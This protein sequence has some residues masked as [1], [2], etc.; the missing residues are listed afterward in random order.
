MKLPVY[1]SAVLAFLLG[2]GQGFS[3][4][5]QAI[6][7]PP[8]PGPLGQVSVYTTAQNTDLR[9]SLAQQQPFVKAVQPLETEVAIFVHPDKTCQTMVG[10][11]GALTDASAE[12]YATLDEATQQEFM[13][14]YFHPEEGIGYTF[15]RTHIHS[16]DFSSKSYTYV[17][18]EDKDLGT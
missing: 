2:P 3:Q 9:L 12:V 6:L 8:P 15:A 17:S 4:A 18:N 11:G 1:I 13:Q 7:N 14:A 5:P 10:I 16:C